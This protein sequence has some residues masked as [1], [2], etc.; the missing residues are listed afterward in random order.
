MVSKWNSILRFLFRRPEVERELDAELQYHVDRQTELNMQ[1]GMSTTE[2]RRQARLSVGGI[3]PLKDECREAR[4]GRTIEVLAQDVRYGLRVLRKNPGYACAT[5]ATLALGIGA[6]TAIFSLIYG[7]F[8]RPLP[9]RDGGQL[10]V[11]HQNVKQAHLND[12]GFSPLEVADYTEHN[13]T[14][15]G[16]VEHHAMTFLLLGKD[17]AERVATSVVSVNF[18]DVL[19]VKP[20]LGRT[21]LPSDDNR[22]SAVLVLSYQYWQGHQGGDPNIVGKVFQMNDMPHTVIGVLPPIPQYPQESDVY[23]PTWQ[24][25]FRSNPKNIA[26]RKFRL[27]SHVFG[28]LKPGVTVEQAQNDLAVVGGQVCSAH[29]ETYP[30]AG[31]QIATDPLQYDL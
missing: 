6:N 9:Y 3:E 18:F 5:I 8:L 29:P 26:N 7:V 23:M 15:N 13:H 11:L 24:C 27:I 22:T 17:T 4:L 12:I 31:F 10:V 19:G 1:R 20:L 21:F 28:R 14:L 2:A 16:V 25:P 30:A